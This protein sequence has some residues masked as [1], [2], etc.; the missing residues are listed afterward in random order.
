M[1]RFG[2]NIVPSEQWKIQFARMGEPAYNMNVLDVMEKLPSLYDAPGLM[3]SIST[4]APIG[5]EKFFD[6][7]LDVKRRLYSTSFQFQFS[8]HTT[9]SDMRRQLIPV[10]TWDMRKIAE[11]GEQI[12][13]SGGRKITLNFALMQDVPV[14]PDVL[15]QYFDPAKF[16]IKLTP[17]NPTFM[18]QKNALASRLTSDDECAD[19]VNALRDAGYAVIVSIGELEENAIGSNCGQYASALESQDKTLENSYTYDFQKL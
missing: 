3:P 17:L 6:R 4:V 15:L 13:E 19:V 12:Y 2:S 14:D 1:N 8:L 5:R 10:K 16:I 18:A 11:Y 7:L 9:D